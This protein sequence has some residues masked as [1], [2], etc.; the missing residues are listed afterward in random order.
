MIDEELF[1]L[2]G[3]K[4][5]LFPLAIVDLDNF[6]KLHRNDTQG[7]L[8]RYCL[9]EMTD[10][11][12]KRYILALLTMHQ[13]AIFTVMTKEGKASRRA[14]YV[15]ISDFSKDACNI[16]GIMDKE[17]AQGLHK[18]LRRDKYTYAQDALHTLL[19]FIF[20]RF[21]LE[22]IETTIL[23][24]NKLALALAQKEGFKKEGVMRHYIKINGQFDDVAVLSILRNEWTDKM[25]IPKEAKD[26]NMQGV[27]DGKV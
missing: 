20:N 8:Q 1:M 5:I 21:E 6:V 9:K 23:S 26:F 3:K 13:I 10:D 27:T 2:V 7:Y 17:F 15:Y 11:E 22:R 12:A 4:V 19:N 25:P 24:R 16:S 14:G 18:Q